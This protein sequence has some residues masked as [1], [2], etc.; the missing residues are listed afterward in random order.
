[1]RFRIISFNGVDGEEKS[2]RADGTMCVD[3]EKGL[4]RY[5]ITVYK[6]EVITACPSFPS[7]LS[8]NRS[9]ERCD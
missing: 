5:E 6:N 9:L 2:A 8:T 1:M 3:V 4:A 7:F